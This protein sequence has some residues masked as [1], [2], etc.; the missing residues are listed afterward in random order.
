[1]VLNFYSCTC[2]TD[3]HHPRLRPFDWKRLPHHV[4]LIMT[5]R[6]D[7]ATQKIAKLPPTIL[8]ARKLRRWLPWL[9]LDTTLGYRVSQKP[10]SSQWRPT[11]AISPRDMAEP[12]A[13]SLCQ[14]PGQTKLSSSKT[15][16]LPGSVC[17]CWRSLSQND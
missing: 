11:L 13:R 3:K 9:G 8:G 1:V 12:L 10:V 4:V 15:F 5:A 17:L 16:S 2:R 6:D 7:L 14:S